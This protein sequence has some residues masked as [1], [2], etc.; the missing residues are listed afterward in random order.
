MARGRISVLLS[1]DSTIVREGVQALLAREPDIEVVGLASDY[2]E[3]IEGAER[4]RP[5]VLVTDIRMPPTHSREGIEAARE[6][7]RRRPDTGVVILS[8][9]QDPDYAL[10]LLREEATGCAYLLKDRVANG[11]Q[12]ARA[13][14]EVAAGGS[15]LDPAIVEAIIVGAGPAEEAGGEGPEPGPGGALAA[16]DPSSLVGTTVAGYW[17]EAVVGRGGMGVVYRAQQVRLKRTVALKL[18]APDLAGEVALRE[19]FLRECELAARLEHPNVVTVF[20]AGELGDVLY[21]AMR[22]VDG[23]DLRSLLKAEGRLEPRRAVRLVGQVAGALDA[24]HDCGLVHRDVKPGNILVGAPGTPS[25]H[26]YLCDFGVGKLAASARPLTATGELVGTI[27]YVAPEQIE[28]TSTDARTD[29]YSLGCVLYECL[30][31]KR[32]FCGDRPVEVVFAHLRGPVPRADEH[33]DV[34]QALAVAAAKAMAKNPDDRFSSCGEL[35]RAARAGLER[36]GG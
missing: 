22:Y 28:G 10:A 1:D 19:R 35:V 9:Y 11:D 16:A 18:L 4:T 21:I 7:R 30:T 34:P 13:I 5:Q 32:P 8:Q 33:H 3:L 2:D 24:A 31:G 20:D 6:V 26:A 25:E 36:E 23:A 29:V 27:D 17:V 14:R 15:L 12:L